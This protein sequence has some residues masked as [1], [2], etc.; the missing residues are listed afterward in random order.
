MIL[1]LK[2]I[3][4]NLNNNFVNYQIINS[5][6]QSATITD[7]KLTSDS[8]NE[9]LP[10]NAYFL[11]ENTDPNLVLF[12]AD[13]ILLVDLVISGLNYVLHVVFASQYKFRIR[14]P[15]TWIGQLRL[16]G[17]RGRPDVFINNCHPYANI[18]L[19]DIPHHVVV[20]VTQRT[21]VDCP[22]TII[23]RR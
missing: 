20:C 17:G 2:T 13:P 6:T 8:V 7:G 15:G 22:D 11:V 21:I 3:L 1:S 16:L 19:G 12:F 14:N 4:D 23:D 9:M 18:V 10:V 5:K